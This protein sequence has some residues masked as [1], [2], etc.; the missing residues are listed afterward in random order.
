M[1]DLICPTCAAHAPAEAA[2]SRLGLEG[3]PAPVVYA[4]V[5]LVCE[6]TEDAPHDPAVMA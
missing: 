1:P 6:G 5:T 4:V 2:R 3:D